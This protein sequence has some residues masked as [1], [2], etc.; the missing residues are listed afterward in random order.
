MTLIHN[1]YR[2]VRQLAQT[3]YGSICLCTDEFLPPRR[4][5]LKSV[6]L[7]HAIN[8]LDL[9]S[10]ELQQPDDPRQE[11][12]FANLQRS[13]AAPHPNI[14]QYLDDFIEGQTLY[15][16]LEYCAGG[17]L[18]SSVNC[19]QN[20]RLVCAD[21]L[22]VIKQIAAGVAYLHSHSVAHRDLS[23]ENVML[24]RGVCKVGDFGLSTRT[25][26][27]SFGRV[28][29]AYYMAP[30]V[31]AARAVYDSKAADIWSL[32]IILFVLVTGSPLVSLAKEE[33]AAFRA[34]QKVGVREVLEAWH[35]E[36]LLEESAI[37]LL[38]GM[39]QCNPTKRLTIEQVLD[40][41][42]FEQRTAV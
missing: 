1:R 16:V 37:Q 42:A 9:R 17:D 11:K 27:P 21:A 6:S 7:V 34:F 13:N 10:P 4:V 29:K 32:G 40:H 26:Q 15:F 19:G 35:M 20:Q 3:T 8:M 41:E 28:G 23:L 12:A 2:P 14:V 30:E 24:S 31:V 38:N 33:D 22:A 39:L 36:D 5:V 18:V 25:D